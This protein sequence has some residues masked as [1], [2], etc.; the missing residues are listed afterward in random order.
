MWY[1]NT[2]ENYFIAP[3]WRAGMKVCPMHEHENI[4]EVY[5]T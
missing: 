5:R 2:C 1:C 4:Q 3:T